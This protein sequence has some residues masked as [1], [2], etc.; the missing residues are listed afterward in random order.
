MFYPVAYSDEYVR[1]VVND[2]LRIAERDRLAA[3]ATGPGR[4]VRARVAGWLFAAA[5]RI[6]GQPRATTLAHAKA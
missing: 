4:P 3:Q 5:R 6:E 1:E 2:R